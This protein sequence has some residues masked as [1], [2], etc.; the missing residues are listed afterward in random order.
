MA[1]AIDTGRARS[2]DFS[3]LASAQSLP[4]DNAAAEQTMAEAGKMYPQSAFVLARYSYVL[5][6]NEK[7]EDAEPMLAKA[8]TRNLLDANAWWAL[9]WNGSDATSAEAHKSPGEFTPLMDLRPIN[10]L[11]AVR[12]ERFVRF[13]EEGKRLDLLGRNR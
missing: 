4:G 9:F 5:A 6:A 3:H 13:P 10:A 11:Y 7:T 12:D 8:R 2:V 1:E